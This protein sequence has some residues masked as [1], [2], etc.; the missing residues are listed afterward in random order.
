LLAGLLLVSLARSPALAAPIDYVIFDKDTLLDLGTFTV[1][2]TLASPNGTSN[3]EMTAFSITD[4]I[5]TY[6]SLTV[7]LDDLISMSTP[8]ARFVDGQIN[9]ISSNTQYELPGNIG[10]NVDIVPQVAPVDVNFVAVF[11][12]FAVTL[13]G[14]TNM[15]VGPTRGIG[16]R[17]AAVPEPSTMLLMSVGTGA[18]AIL[19]R[20][21]LRALE[22]GAAPRAWA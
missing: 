18:I 17:E 12:M 14:L 8:H 2:P 4:T 22:A 21:R 7:T 16:I 19:R 3:V 15:H 20:R 5:A 6:G 1:D 9:A 13:P 10:V 11:Q